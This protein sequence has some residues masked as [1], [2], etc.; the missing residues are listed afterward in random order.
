[1]AIC[2]TYAHAPTVGAPDTPER[3]RLIVPTGVDGDTGGVMTSAYR[4]SAI[5]A[6]AAPLGLLAACTYPVE[7]RT[8]YIVVEPDGGTTTTTSTT[9]TGSGTGGT[10]TT[11]ATGGGGAVGGGGGSPDAGPGD[12]AGDSGVNPACPPRPCVAIDPATCEFWPVAGECP[13]GTCVDGGC[14]LGGCVQRAQTC[15]L[16]GIGEPWPQWGCSPVGVS[17]PSPYCVPIG[18]GDSNGWCCPPGV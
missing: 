7:Y 9:D 4:L 8:T 18:G 11:S 2:T 16:P 1:M 12:D 13:G 17:L 15:T 3:A 5:V 10:T 6:V 14:V